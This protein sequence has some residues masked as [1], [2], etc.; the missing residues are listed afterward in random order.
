[1]KTKNRSSGLS[2]MLESYYDVDV[3]K[4]CSDCN[5]LRQVA[6]LEYVNGTNANIDSGLW[7]HHMVHFNTG[8][9][10]WDPVGINGGTCPGCIPMDGLAAAPAYTTP[11]KPKPAGVSAKTTE[12]FFVTGNERTP[13]NF[14]SDPKYPSAYHLDA[15]DKFFFLVELMN[16]N[17]QDA[18]VYITMTYDVTDGP[19]PTGWKDVKTVFLDAN[20][21]GSSEVDSPP[22]LHAFNIN[23]TKHTYKPNIEGRIVD[24]IG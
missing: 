21:C 16:M 1:M 12:R 19:L 23:S 3:E 18:L 20:S 14:F 11:N 6:G 2:G 22:G 13:F 10:R 15:A 8:P 5:I 4:P 9:R 17:D 24:S 7:L